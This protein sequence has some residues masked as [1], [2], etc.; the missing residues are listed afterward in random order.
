MLLGL[1]AGPLL[2]RGQISP[3]LDEYI[4]TGMNSNLTLQ[5]KQVDVE[6]SLEA[7]RPAKG[8]FYPTLQF[9]ANYTRA[10]GRSIDFPIGDLL[11]PVYQTLN[12]LTQS[13]SF[14]LVDNAKVQFLPDNFQ[15]T[16]VQFQVP[17]LI[18]T[19]ATTAGSRKS[20]SMANQPLN[21]F[22]SLNS[23]TTLPRHT[24]NTYKPWKPKKL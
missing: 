16:Y 10:G 13:N 19:S 22:T 4:Q 2:A 6:Q 5:Q 17:V 15:E 11:N 9:N 1:V 7:V 12:S 8:L 24:F 3:V 20:M 21:H 23:G 14:P 18:R